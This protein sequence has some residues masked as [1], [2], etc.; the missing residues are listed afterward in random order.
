MTMETGVTDFRVIFEGS[1]RLHT[2]LFSH[3]SVKVVDCNGGTRSPLSHPVQT[4]VLHKHLVLPCGEKRWVFVF[5]FWLKMWRSAQGGL[6]LPGCLPIAHPGEAQ[7]LRCLPWECARQDA[8]SWRKPW[9]T[10]ARKRK[11]ER[12]SAHESDGGP[13][14]RR[15]INYAAEAGLAVGRDPDP[16]HIPKPRRKYAN[17]ACSA[18]GNTSLLSPSLTPSLSLSHSFT[19]L[20]SLFLLFLLDSLQLWSSFFTSVSLSSVLH[21]L[22]WPTF[23]LFTQDPLKRTC[24]LSCQSD[25]QPGWK[26]RHSSGHPV[27]MMEL[28]IQLIPT[29][30]I[31][32]PPG[33]NGESY[34]HNCKVSPAI[35]IFLRVLHKCINT[36]FLKAMCPP[37][38]GDNAE[39]CQ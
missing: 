4:D 20:H 5:L 33:K 31:I 1:Q 10:R 32:L 3:L 6:C 34:C 9:R 2:H 11:R 39:A 26:D 22:D 38:K 28:K 16:L 12:E 14:P 24:K 23:S 36:V 35:N 17:A 18:T 37:F 30:E 7:F 19:P 29:G 8:E 13:G 25:W 27:N 21:S 15:N